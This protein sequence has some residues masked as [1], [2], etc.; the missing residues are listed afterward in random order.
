MEDSPEILEKLSVKPSWLKLIPQDNRQRLLRSGESFTVY[1]TLTDLLEL[2]EKNI[3]V[4]NA[5][6][7]MLKDPLV[8]A[9]LSNLP[10]WKDFKVSGHN[11]PRY[12]PNQLLLLHN[13][14]IKVEDD[15]RIKNILDSLLEH[16]D[17]DTGQFLWY[18]EVYNRKTKEK[19]N[20]W[21][22]ILCDHHLITTLM[23]LF[24][25]EQKSAVKSAISRINDL[26]EDTEN[27]IGWKCLP[28][29]KSQFRGPGR[30]N[31][32]C[33]MLIIDVLRGYYKIP[34]A[35]R[36]ANLIKCGKTLLNCWNDRS[37]KKP[38]MFGHG[39]NFRSLKPPFFWYNVGTVLDAT[40][41]YPK[42][43]NTLSFKQLLSV[44][45]LSFDSK[46]EIT[47]KSIKTFFKGYSFGQKKNFSPW[48]T[49][50]L[51]S[52]CKRA[53]D[54][55]VS[56]INEVLKLDGNQFAGSKDTTKKK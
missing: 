29:L 50:Y 40:S 27:G 42:L 25:Y 16:T 28:G 31:E 17:E 48:V 24:G 12:I 23:L 8:E 49:Y 4:Q 46:G 2:P 36:P 32:V 1:K 39:R 21:E 53:V 37:T 34:L 47:P 55:N 6:A 35:K 38:Y 43:V 14:G 7:K 19:L 18:G 41:Y 51:S 22:S 56:L 45:L 30:K 13:W 15:I 9:I 33:P 10:R 26:V 3:T 54:T 5:K 20:M 44:A 11:D 52:I